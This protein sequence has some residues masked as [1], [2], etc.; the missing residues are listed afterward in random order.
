MFLNL[1]H[2]LGLCTLAALL[3]ACQTPQDIELAAQLARRDK[4]KALLDERCK[5][6]GVV[7]KRTV[8]EVEGFL[9]MKVTPKV[10]YVA[11]EYADP[12]WPWAALAA[13]SRGDTFIKTFF[14]QEW[15]SETEPAV[16]GYLNYDLRYTGSVRPP[17]NFRGYRYVDIVDPQDGLRYRYTMKFTYVAKTNHWNGDLQREPATGPM[18][19][20]AVDIEHLVDPVDRAQW[21][22]GAITK[23]IDRTTGEVVATKTQYVLDG[24]LGMTLRDRDPWLQAATSSWTCPHDEGSYD[25]QVRFFVDTVLIPKQG[26]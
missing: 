21:V 13:E 24:G 8:P 19:R 23:V 4:A 9:L 11:K 25:T 10:P 6:A 2:S 26:D 22:A 15:R 20:Y 1:K 18:P 17:P 16:H 14:M 5:G 12:M 7:V 3:S